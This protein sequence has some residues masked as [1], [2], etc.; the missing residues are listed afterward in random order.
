VLAGGVWSAARGVSEARRATEAIQDSE[1][2]MRALAENASDLVYVLGNDD[3]LL[4]VSPSCERILGFTR[5]EMLAMPIGALVPEQER[6]PIL[7]LGVRL[8]SGEELTELYVHRLRNKDGRYLWFETGFRRV[9]DSELGT[10]HIHL[11]SRDITERLRFATE[12]KESEERL[13][14][15]RE[16]ALKEHADLLR[17][18]SVR[19][20]LTA[21]YNRRG[22]GE[23]AGQA[24]R[25]LARSKTAGCL[26]F[27]DLD[28]L[29]H[30]NDTQGHE[31]G[32]RAIVAAAKVL[33][34]VFR[35][36]DVVARLG[37]DEFAILAL[38]CGLADIPSVLDRIAQR[39]ADN[40]SDTDFVLSMSIGT[41]LFEPPAL[42]DFDALMDQ[43]DHA[44]YE[45]KRLLKQRRLG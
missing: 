7:L 14:A 38:E 1:R 26:F 30:I 9:H 37:G 4:Y 6:E 16:L 31:T 24:L 3:E 34:D 32:D 42:A 11:T 22:F 12:L 41:A 27:V 19:D 18:I 40:N 21:L 33:T 25:A 23:V 39:V 10:D 29:K 8:R 13:R 2:A 15:Q 35:D 43:A 28:G 45:Q 5:D 20:E 44:M 17:S 36:S